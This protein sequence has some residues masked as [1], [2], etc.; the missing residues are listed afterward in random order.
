MVCTINP[1][2]RRGERSGQWGHLLRVVIEQAVPDRV[3]RMKL[4]RVG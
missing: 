3:A 2:I 4:L 1:V